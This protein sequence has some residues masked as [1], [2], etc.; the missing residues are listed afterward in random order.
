MLTK[1]LIVSLTGRKK[2]DWQNK[3]K[4]INQHRLQE[5]GL[6]MEVFSLRERAGL[7]EALKNSCVKKIPLVHIR[8][9]TTKQEILFLKK[10][11]GSRY[12]TIHE[13]HFH[14]LK[15][16]RG[17]YQNLYLELN[18]D[19]HLA[20]YV[21]VE[22]IGGFCVDLAHFKKEVTKQIKEYRYTIEEIGKVKFACNHVSGYSYS[23]N[24]DLHTIKSVRDFDYLATLPHNLF[25]Q[26]MAFEFF[27]PIK[28]QLKYQKLLKKSLKKKLGFKII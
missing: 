11:F 24:T 3:L 28:E 8:S 26:V 21:N 23:R 18:T 10:N 15:Q 13:P 19:D 9:D 14:I 22:K 1:K 16:W 5:I 25:G 12:F 6:F 2:K 27:N 17:Y 4:E 20:K 7:L